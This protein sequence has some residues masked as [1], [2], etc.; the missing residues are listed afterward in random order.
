[1]LKYFE[2]KKAFRYYTK[3]IDSMLPC[4]WFSNNRR[5][6]N[7]VRTT[8]THSATPRVPLF[9]TYHILT[10]SVIYYWTDAQQHGIYLLNILVI[11]SEGGTWPC[12]DWLNLAVAWTRKTKSKDRE[13]DIVMQLI[14]CF[15][16][17]SISS[18]MFIKA[19]IENVLWSIRIPCV[20]H[21]IQVK[22]PLT[23]KNV[24][25]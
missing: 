7:V 8:V 18:T 25:R 17:S 5:R 19:V 3:Q 24:F 11:V 22:V 15:H 20:L 23:P 1:M 9:C 16:E 13:T 21:V 12:Y 4:V 14:Y 2:I 6:Q 10:S